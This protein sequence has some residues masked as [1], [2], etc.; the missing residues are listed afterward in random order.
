MDNFR[1]SNLNR[2]FLSLSPVTF[3]SPTI[4]RIQNDLG[5]YPFRSL[6]FPKAAVHTAQYAAGTVLCQWAA[7]SSVVP[8]VMYDTS[9]VN[10]LALQRTKCRH[11]WMADRCTPHAAG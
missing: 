11:E 2:I 9:K 8:S 7:L 1:Q 4:N 5:H 6:P 10:L 3:T